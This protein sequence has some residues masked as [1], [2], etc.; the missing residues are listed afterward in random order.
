[1]EPN[2]L[3]QNRGDGRFD[4][5]GNVTGLALRLDSRGAATSDID[6]DGDLDL[7]VYNRNAPLIRIYRNDTPGQGGAL[8]VDLDAG[9]R[10]TEGS[11]VRLRCGERILLRQR[12]AGAGFLSQNSGTLHFGLGACEGVEAIEVRWP[13]GE[14][15]TFPGTK[16]EQRLR[17]VR[18]EGKVARAQPL[19]ARNHNRALRPGLSGE[20]SAELPPVSFEALGEG[21]A[22]DLAGLP[23]GVQVLNF[24]A[25]WCI[26]C[27]AEMPELVA[28]SQEF[29][30]RGVSFYGV[31]M[32]ER[33]KLPEVQAFLERF[34]VPYPQVWGSADAMA[35]F[36]NLAS[37]PNGSIPITVVIQDRVVRSISAGA[38]HKAKLA[39]LLTALTGD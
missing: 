1:M 5:V 8:L 30:D 21:E 33:D 25:T 6:G 14:L 26:P 16:A 13:D 38:I 2:W 22:L 19:R 32:D 12:D 37:V 4:E 18:G 27:A 39:E 35:P 31:S 28:L 29:A 15:E 34:T 36:A 10:P 17:L 9:G 11:Q 3:F 24:W 23:D 20:L 7:A